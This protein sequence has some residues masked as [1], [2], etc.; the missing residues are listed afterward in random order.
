MGRTAGYSTGIKPI[1]G[2]DNKPKK[3]RMVT[4]EGEYKLKAEMNELRQDVARAGNELHRRKHQRKS[5]KKR[6]KS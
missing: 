6:R 4:G 2:N 1:E 5:T 3:V